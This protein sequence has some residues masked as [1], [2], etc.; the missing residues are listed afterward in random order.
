MSSINGIGGIG[1]GGIPPKKKP[2]FDFF[3]KF[4]KKAQPEPEENEGDVLELSD[5][6]LAILAIQELTRD[7]C[8]ELAIDEGFRTQLESVPE[9]TRRLIE[10]AFRQKLKE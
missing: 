3:R 5:A 6:A 7:Q 8:A 4:R 9:E 2:P 10:A 1:G